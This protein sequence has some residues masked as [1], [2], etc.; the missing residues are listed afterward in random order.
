MSVEITYEQ[1]DYEGILR[2]YKKSFEC[3]EKAYSWIQTM[4]ESASILGK[5]FRIIDGIINK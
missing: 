4:K 3:K 2:Q 1:D 5:P